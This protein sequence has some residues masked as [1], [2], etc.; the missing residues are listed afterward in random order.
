MIPRLIRAAIAAF[1]VF[2]SYAS[3]SQPLPESVITLL[4]ETYAG[5]G[6]PHISTQWVS[7]MLPCKE[8]QASLTRDPSPRGGRVSVMVNCVEGM[9]YIQVD[10][11]VHQN[12]VI[13]TRAMKRGQVLASKDIT[14]KPSI[15]SD[16]PRHALTQLSQAEGMILALPVEAEQVL[17]SS[18]IEAPV[19]VNRNDV[20]TII[21]TGDGFSI[22][23]QATALD[24]GA[25]GE[26]IRVRMDNRE[27]ITGR[28][29]S[30]GML[31]ATGI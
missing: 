1:F 25:Y 16:E 9:R 15:L 11:D 8:P 21:A 5:L 10:V 26:V 7:G 27:I 23:R 24:K 6:H 29:T 4:E 13:S 18:M 2:T 14:I 3:A 20:V 17:T 31:E 30:R 12:V 22:S 28:V 19:L